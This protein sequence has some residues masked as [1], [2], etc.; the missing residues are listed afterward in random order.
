[1]GLVADPLEQLEG[2]VPPFG[3]DRLL[4]HLEVDL[5]LALGDRGHG[6]HRQPDP[7]ER[8]DREAELPRPAVDQHQ[9]R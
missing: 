1:M 7:R 4:A 5:L 6:Q 8:A 3:P 2:R 9:I